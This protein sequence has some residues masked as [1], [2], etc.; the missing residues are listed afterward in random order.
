MIQL[1]QL[2]FEFVFIIIFISLFS[3]GQA[4]LTYTQSV[5]I[6]NAIQMSYCCRDSECH[7]NELLL[8]HLFIIIMEILLKNSLQK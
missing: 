6:V 1:D 2:S 5:E 7:T 3:S 4:C 8:S